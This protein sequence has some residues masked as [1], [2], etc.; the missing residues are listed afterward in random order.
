MKIILTTVLVIFSQ[1]TFAQE[2]LEKKYTKKW[3]ANSPEV[4]EKKGKYLQMKKRLDNGRI[5]Q[6]CIRLKDNFVMWSKTFMNGEPVGIW[7]KHYDN[8]K[9][10]SRLN[11]D[12]ELNYSE[13][14]PD[15]APYMDLY[16]LKLK[17]E[18]NNVF[19]P[20]VISGYPDGFT[21]YLVKNLRYPDLAVRNRLSGK[22]II[23]ISID[24]KGIKT[25]E[26][27]LKG[28]HKYLD[29]EAYRLLNELVIDKPAMINNK[30]IK[31]YSIVPISFRIR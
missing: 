30:P 6:T 28:A 12:Q 10:M 21:S 27:I 24:E 14:Q 22:V 11:Y 25:V 1:F 18:T 29:L 3:Y 26:S 15:D 7:F 8:G 19:T 4:S 23:L 16:S 5:E 31:I 2:T 13:K 20:P 17:D 9:L